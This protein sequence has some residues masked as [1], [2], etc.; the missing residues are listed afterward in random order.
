MV[1]M[2]QC[3]FSFVGLKVMLVAFEDCFGPFWKTTAET[4]EK[5]MEANKGRVSRPNKIISF[6]V[7]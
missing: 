4:V 6:C 7:I 5:L 3:D 2:A 1:L